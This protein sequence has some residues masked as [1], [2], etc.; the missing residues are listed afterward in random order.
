M[1]NGV[2]AL[3]IEWRGEGWENTLGWE[4][5]EGEGVIQTAEKL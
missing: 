5:K 4:A 3:K 2:K 1:D